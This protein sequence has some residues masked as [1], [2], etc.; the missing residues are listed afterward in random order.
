MV[1]VVH[2]RAVDDA[3]DGASA[4]GDVESEVRVLP[5]RHEKVVCGVWS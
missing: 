4:L 2:C 5:F 1:I 3:K